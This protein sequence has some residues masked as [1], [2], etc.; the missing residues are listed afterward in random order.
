MIQKTGFRNLPEESNV[1]REQCSLNQFFY[2]K[3]GRRVCW[4]C[5]NRRHSSGAPGLWCETCE[6]RE[7][8]VI[9]SRTL[10]MVPVSLARQWSGC[11]KQQ[12]GYTGVSSCFMSSRLQMTSTFHMQGSVR[13]CIIPDVTRTNEQWILPHLSLTGGHLYMS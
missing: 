13:T 10:P 3:P 7:V 8:I 6:R 5:I 9:A 2:D 1:R 11:T 12:Y 4:L